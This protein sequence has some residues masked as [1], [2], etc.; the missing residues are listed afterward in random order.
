M[1]VLLRSHHIDKSDVVLICLPGEIVRHMPGR[2]RSVKLR[3]VF[4]YWFYCLPSALRDGRH[5]VTR[6]WKIIQVDNA[7]L[8]F[9][10]S[11]CLYLLKTKED[12][13]M[14]Q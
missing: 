10:F 12:D 7:F 5:S 6:T 11:L 1:L 2:A 9:M 8:D 13:S 14:T 4:L 3:T